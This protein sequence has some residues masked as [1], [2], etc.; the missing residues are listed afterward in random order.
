MPDVRL[1]IGGRQFIVTC[2]PG[3]E[4]RLSEL[5]SMVDGV[6]RAASADAA[7]LT[8]SR[9][10]LYAA[11]H[12]ADQ[13]SDMRERGGAIHDLFGSAIPL[14]P[15]NAQDNEA[16]EALERLARRLENLATALE[17]SAVTT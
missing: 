11:L 12:L 16:A 6:A 14:P 15:T 4:A 1:T 3:D 17:Q 13:L 10:L 7:G 2:K 5:G 8:E 9:M